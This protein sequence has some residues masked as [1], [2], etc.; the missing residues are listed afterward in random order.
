MPSRGYLSQSELPVTFGLGTAE[1]VEQVTIRW[2]DGS[3][4]DVPP[5]DLWEGYAFDPADYPVT[6]WDDNGSFQIY[7]RQERAWGD[8]KAVLLE[9]R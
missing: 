3:V 2:P 9:G 8:E 1:H 6:V 5:P 7:R 4:Q